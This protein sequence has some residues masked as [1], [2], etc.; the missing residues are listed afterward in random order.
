MQTHC[1]CER[2]RTSRMTPAYHCVCQ[3]CR[4]APRPPRPSGSAGWRSASL[5][6]KRASTRWPA[7]SAPTA[8]AGGLQAARELGAVLGAVVE[9]T[10]RA[11]PDEP[12]DCA[13]SSRGDERACRASSFVQAARDVI[14]PALAS[15]DD[16]NRE[17]FGVPCGCTDLGGV[18]CMPRTSSFSQICLYERRFSPSDGSMTAMSAAVTRVLFPNAPVVR[19]V[20]VRSQPRQTAWKLVFEARISS[21]AAC[22]SSCCAALSTA[23]GPA[24]GPALEDASDAGSVLPGPLQASELSPAGAAASASPPSPLLR[25]RLVRLTGSEAENTAGVDADASSSS[26]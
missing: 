9:A 5:A 11:A 25:D 26:L 19:H 20:L 15:D 1:A 17:H 4:T 22:S 7:A 12:D 2:V 18:S 10:G 8:A 14:A 21:M 23:T 6:W 16:D 13:C 24:A 3:S